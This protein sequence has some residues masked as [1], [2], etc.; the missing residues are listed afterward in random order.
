MAKCFNEV[1]RSTLGIIIIGPYSSLLHCLRAV[2]SR[3]VDISDNKDD[4]AK[5]EASRIVVG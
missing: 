2:L 1:I 4:H 5:E 3:Y